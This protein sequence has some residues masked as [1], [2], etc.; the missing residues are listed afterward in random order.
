MRP[1]PGGRM[2]PPAGARVRAPDQVATVSAPS[3]SEIA[4]SIE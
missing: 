1:G 2:R 4:T 3:C